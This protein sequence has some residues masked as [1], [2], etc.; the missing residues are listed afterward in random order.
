MPEQGTQATP[1]HLAADGPA[2]GGG[3]TT[4]GRATGD[5]PV[6]LTLSAADAGRLANC[7]TRLDWFI[8]YPHSRAAVTGWLEAED[9]TG[10]Y[11]TEGRHARKERRRRAE[12]AA[13]ELG[14]DARRLLEQLRAVLPP[15]G[16]EP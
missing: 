14:Y 8:Q 16:Q 2:A 13:H 1:T 12:L 15:P 6:T 3:A 5:T 9:P 7:L 11:H 4:G 10:T